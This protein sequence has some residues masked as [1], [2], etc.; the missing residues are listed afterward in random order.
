MTC[1]HVPTLKT[2]SVLGQSGRTCFNTSVAPICAEFISI[3]MSRILKPSI[4]AIII[5]L[6]SPCTLH[7]WS[8]GVISLRSWMIAL[9]QIFR[10][11]GET[12]VVYMY[13]Q[14]LIYWSDIF[15]AV[16][17]P[18]YTLKEKRNAPPCMSIFL[19]CMKTIVTKTCWCE[20]S[21]VLSERK[22]L[23]GSAT[24]L[25]HQ[26]LFCLFVCLF[27]CLFAIVTHGSKQNE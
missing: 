23:S 20:F 14:H 11:I 24:L 2:I 27:V 8:D 15:K 5:Y 7:R 19:K 3:S 12:Q 25:N 9:Y 13:V 4:P 18:F 6:Q 16:E 21:T 26:N 17:V 10:P 22:M 1:L